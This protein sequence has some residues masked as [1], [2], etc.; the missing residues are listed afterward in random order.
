[1][2]VDPAVIL[3]REIMV[4]WIKEKI[5][6]AVLIFLCLAFCLAGCSRGPGKDVEISEGV[7]R[8][9]TGYDAN[10]YFIYRGQPMGFE[11]ELLSSPAPEG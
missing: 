5:N 10:S 6:S 4:L 9:V 11:Y 2:Y 1:M 8:A 3:N 7:L